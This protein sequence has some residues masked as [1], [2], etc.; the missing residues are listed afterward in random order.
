MLTPKS[1]IEQ[2]L[3]KAEWTTEESRWLLDFLKNSGDNELNNIMQSHFLNDLANSKVI[4]PVISETLLDRIHQRIGSTQKKERVKLVYI[5]GVRMAA[6]CVVGLLTFST[7]LWVKH[8]SKP[9]LAQPQVNKIKNNND[10]EPGGNKAVLTLANGATIVLD[11]AM[12]GALAQQG[13]TKVIK[14]N[15]KLDYK[16]SGAENGEVLYNMI[17]TP[18]GGQYQVELPDG[19]QVWL[20]A[21]SSLRF[22]TSFIEKERRV[23]ITGEAYFEVAK[24]KAQPF[25]VSANGAEIQVIGTH[26]NVNAYNDESTIST[27][28]LEGVVKFVKDGN[29]ITLAPGQQSQLTKNG[30][31]KIVRDVDVDKVV[32]WKNGFFIFEGSD[33]Q[34]VSRQLSRWYDVEVKYDKKID[35]L[36]YAEIPRNTR[37][38]DV[39]K[40]LELTGKIHFKI[41]GR[42]IIVLP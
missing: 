19:S 6:A 27:T 7:F 15:G 8:N 12:N 36:L 33:F 14:I 11:D 42:E 32:A 24:N 23:E 9:E 40:A 13:N 1:K 21:A 35:D 25:I 38:S 17:A 26:F 5:W 18:R 41:E 34:T 16:S 37:L 10:V 4:D 39:L 20:N 28:L 31:L 22:P 2:L 29:N 3:E 30:Q